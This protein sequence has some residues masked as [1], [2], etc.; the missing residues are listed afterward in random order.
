VIPYNNLALICL[1]LVGKWKSYS[2]MYMK[3]K[4]TIAASAFARLEDRNDD[5]RVKPVNESS[6]DSCPKTCSH[7]FRLKAGKTLG[8]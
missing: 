3:R 5:P 8:D 7:S 4:G 2:W 1:A 6:M